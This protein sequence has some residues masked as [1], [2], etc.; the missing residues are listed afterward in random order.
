MS[1]CFM[2]LMLMVI[3]GGVSGFSFLAA[4]I[5]NAGFGTVWTFKVLAICAI[6]GLLYDIFTSYKGNG[7]MF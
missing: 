5:F 1:M 4:W 2:F 3:Y 6:L 7:K